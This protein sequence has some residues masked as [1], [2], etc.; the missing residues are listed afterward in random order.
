M[1]VNHMHKSLKLTSNVA[2]KNRVAA[3]SVLSLRNA[4]LKMPVFLD[5]M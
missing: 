4:P 2:K 5:C 3:A 1:T